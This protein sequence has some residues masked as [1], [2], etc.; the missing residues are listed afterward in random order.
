MKGVYKSKLGVATRTIDFLQYQ[1]RDNNKSMDD[2][3]SFDE[4]LKFLKAT[5]FTRSCGFNK[6]KRGYM[7]TLKFCY[8]LKEGKSNDKKL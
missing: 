4:F 7:E 5:N 8:S 6:N 1:L 2:F 3:N